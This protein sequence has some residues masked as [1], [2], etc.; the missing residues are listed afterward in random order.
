M[1]RSEDTRRPNGKIVICHLVFRLTYGG[2]ENGLV[3]L[4]NHLDHH[5][6]RH[7]V[8][9]LTES[10]EFEDR[11]QAGADCV[12]V[13][14]G[15][16]AQGNSLP[17]YW[18]VWRLLRRLRPDIVHT[19]NLPVVD[20]GLIARLAC[21]RRLVHSEHGLDVIEL[22][23][24]RR[25]VWMRR[26]LRPMV[27]RYIALGRDL[28]D[29]LVREVKIR[30]EKVEVI[31]NGV[32]VDR[33]RPAAKDEREAL[34]AMLPSGFQGEQ[35][36]I[37]G[38]VGRMASLKRPLRLIEAVGKLVADRP[39]LRS[40]LRIVMIGDGEQRK[41]VESAVA[42]LRLE[43][44]VWIS[45]FR[46]DVPE[47]MRCLDI[48]VLPSLREGLSNTLLEAM[49]SGLPV[50]ATA[51]GGTPELVDDGRTGCL[52]LPERPDEMAATL[53]ELVD[54]GARRSNMGNQA[55]KDVCAQFS[56]AEMVRHYDSLYRAVAN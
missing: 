10:G 51:V 23:G 49:A 26:L 34:R 56:I 44:Q 27:S 7:V 20:L 48:F 40:R 5:R 33:F 18:R 25:Y 38:T 15:K 4:V 53:I 41:A 24:T 55:R 8:V 39:D 32:D 35:T 54:D 2:L 47:L 30:P 12:I 45:G 17:V 1:H 52:V 14:L 46:D 29:W 3:N 9:C 37:I 31:Y 13:A 42:R 36:V 6:Y 11:I 43:D 28:K 16:P 50:V 21:V 19:R 22:S